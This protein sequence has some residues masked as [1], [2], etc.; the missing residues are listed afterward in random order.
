MVHCISSSEPDSADLNM[1]NSENEWSTRTH[2]MQPKTD[3]T[4][5]TSVGGQLHITKK[6][7]TP[8][9]MAYAE[10][11]TVVSGIQFVTDHMKPQEAVI[12]SR[13]FEKMSSKRKHSDT[14]VV[15]ENR[16]MHLSLF[17]DDEGMSC[18]MCFLL[19]I[20]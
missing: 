2:H 4:D 8:I 13:N 17:E 19:S 6:S 5:I 14:L 18:F 1:Q 7:N 20:V 15:M 12:S 9:H 11:S 10:S 3:Y 16:H